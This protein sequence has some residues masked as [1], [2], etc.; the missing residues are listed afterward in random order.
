MNGGRPRERA[1]ERERGG[2]ERGRTKPSRAAQSLTA[3]PNQ[4]PAPPVI[5]SPAWTTHP[6]NPTSLFPCVPLVTWFPLGL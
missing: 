4:P 3:A 6:V 1:R 5:N 2:G